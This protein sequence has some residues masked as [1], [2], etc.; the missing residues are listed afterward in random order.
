MG[1]VVLKGAGALLTWRDGELVSA[2][3][4]DGSEVAVDG[5]TLKA[6]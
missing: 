6:E 5:R 2:L 1:D 3:L 4:A